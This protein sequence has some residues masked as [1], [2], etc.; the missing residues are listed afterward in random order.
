VEWIRINECGANY[1]PLGVTDSK[2]F[3]RVTLQ[4][5]SLERMAFQTSTENERA[6]SDEELGTLR[7]EKK[8]TV[9]WQ[10]QGQ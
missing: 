9:T 2:S 5:Q 3:V 8:L 4:P 10:G 1:G 6:L 7:R